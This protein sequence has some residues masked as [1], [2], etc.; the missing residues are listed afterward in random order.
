VEEGATAI[1]LID[2]YFGDTPAVWH[3]E[4]LYALSRNVSVGGGASMGALR[5]AECQPFGMVGIGKI[6]SDYKL[7]KLVD[8]EAVALVHAPQELDWAPLSVPRVDYEATMCKLARMGVISAAERERFLLTASFMHYSERTY[9]SIAERCEWGSPQRCQEILL[10][11]HR[12]RVEQK[13]EDALAVLAWLD[14][15][16]DPGQRAPWTFSQTSHWRLLRKE[17]ASRIMK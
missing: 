12:H 9:A 4:I 6:Y 3:K 7:G 10:Q 2:G 8:D 13:R 16:D 5:A 1:G 17:L 15:S 14:Q 11:I